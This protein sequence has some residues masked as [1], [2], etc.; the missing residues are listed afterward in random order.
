M[1]SERLVEVFIMGIEDKMDT[2]IKLLQNLN[3]YLHIIFFGFAAIGLII[4]LYK[5]LK[6]FI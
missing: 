3:C 1:I 5:F 4:L 6:I 2:I